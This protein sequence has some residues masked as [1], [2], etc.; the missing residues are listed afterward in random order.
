MI[1]ATM[2]RDIAIQADPVGS[3][4]LL[5]LVTCGLAAVLFLLGPDP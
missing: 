3:W 4:W 2:L 1:A 5:G